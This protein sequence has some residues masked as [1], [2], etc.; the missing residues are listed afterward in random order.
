M[1]AAGLASRAT[2]VPSCGTKKGEECKLEKHSDQ[3]TLKN[4]HS[5][6]VFK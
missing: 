5:I 4:L 1:S 2:H 3:G 6:N